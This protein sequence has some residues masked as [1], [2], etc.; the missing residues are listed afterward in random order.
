MT[1]NIEGL[2]VP[3][4][5]PLNEPFT[6]ESTDDEIIDEDEDEDL[7]DF[8]SSVKESTTPSIS[9]FVESLSLE[10]RVNFNNLL[11]DGTVSMQCS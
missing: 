5:N 6:E 3:E 9:H 1:D 10:E 8:G 7:S 4:M 2:Q 11:L